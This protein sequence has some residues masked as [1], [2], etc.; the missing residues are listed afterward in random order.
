[1]LHNFIVYTKEEVNKRTPPLLIVVRLYK[2]RSMSMKNI[3]IELF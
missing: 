2:I 3:T 1:M